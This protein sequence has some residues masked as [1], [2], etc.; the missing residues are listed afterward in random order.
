MVALGVHLGGLA[1]AAGIAV[2]ISRLPSSKSRD[3]IASPKLV[4]SVVNEN[5]NWR[6]FDIG[7]AVQCPQ[8]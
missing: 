6:L 3:S 8:V 4:L 2:L 5:A 1:S 7:G